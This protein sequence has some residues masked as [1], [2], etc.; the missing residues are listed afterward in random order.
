MKSRTYT[1]ISAEMMRFFLIGIH[2]TNTRCKNQ[3]IAH[4]ILNI[5][6]LP[7]GKGRL[8]KIT[9]TRSV[10]RD[11]FSFVIRY[12]LLGVLYSAFS[13]LLSAGSR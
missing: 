9:V 6:Y 11:L 3:I 12:S 13:S 8:N 10:S 7:A 4:R 1:L 2:L 5:E